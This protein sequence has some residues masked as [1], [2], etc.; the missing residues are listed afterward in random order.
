MLELD[1]IAVSGASLDE[2]RAYVE[3]ALGVPMQ[4]GGAHAVFGTHNALLA[5]EG[6]LY[7]EAIA[8][9]PNAP[10][11]ERAR[12]FDLD[13]FAGRAR[14]SN[15]ICRSADLPAALAEIDAPLGAPVD[16]V[17]GQYQWQMA[18]PESGILPFDNCAP[19]LLSWQSETQPAAAL[20]PRGVRLTRL[21]VVH[22]QAQELKQV[23][24]HRL[25][26]NRIVF[27]TGPAKIWAEFDTP[28][29][30]RSLSK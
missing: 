4:M 7:L 25:S 28:H 17:R 1:H 30:V 16:L 24:G 19:A 29:G 8:I 5:L 3:E 12:W 9:D 27:E 2:A 14:L 22:P 18:V 13:R 21:T 15:W 23:L 20:T 11:P 26:D 10:R 6:G